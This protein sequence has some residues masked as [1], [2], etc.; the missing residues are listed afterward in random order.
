MTTRDKQIAA[1]RQRKE[2]L[3]P[4]RL[5]DC[6][7]HALSSY[8]AESIVDGLA[9]IRE[10]QDSRPSDFR[11]VTNTASYQLS[12][13]ND[14]KTQW[15]L[16]SSELGRSIAI[17]ERQYVFQELQQAPLYG[18]SVDAAGPEFDVIR[19][20]AV[21]L[22]HKG[23]RPNVLCVPI[24]FFVELSQHPRHEYDSTLERQTFRVEGNRT[25]NIYWSSKIHAIR[26]MY[27]L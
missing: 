3:W 4:D 8:K 6:Y 11:V 9:T 16:L 23:Y 1:I 17:G 5:K 27:H 7:D 20:A 25:L 22:I 18:E 13:F 10:E 21:S 2:R 24:A 12:Q 19:R 26:P 15:H 14:D